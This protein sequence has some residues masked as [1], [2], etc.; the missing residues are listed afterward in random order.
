MLIF[1]HLGGETHC[2][3]RVSFPSPQQIEQNKS[4]SLWN[5]RKEFPT[6]KTSYL[7]SHLALPSP[8]PYLSIQWHSRRTHLAFP[9][10]Q[11]LSDSH[12]AG[13]AETKLNIRINIERLGQW[14]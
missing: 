10:K 5:R 7:L 9:F 4:V 14:A 3:S 12:I 13:I 8:Y 2:E 11:S 1:L 6:K